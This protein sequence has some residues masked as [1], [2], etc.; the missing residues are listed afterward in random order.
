[1]FSYALRSCRWM[2]CR[3]YQVVAPILQLKVSNGCF[4]WDGSP[5]IPTLKDLNFQD[6][7]G[8]RVAVYGMIGSGKSSLLFYSLWDDRLSVRCQSY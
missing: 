8:M 2:I 5:E 4:S 3:G 6:Q 1:M 7:Q